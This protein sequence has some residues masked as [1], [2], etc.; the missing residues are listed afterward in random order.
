VRPPGT[1]CPSSRPRSVAEPG[2]SA[3]P[4]G[5]ESA[6]RAVGTDTCGVLVRKRRCLFALALVRLVD[7]VADETC[8]A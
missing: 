5:R 4:S 7:G 1:M 8:A 6:A 3:S 2:R